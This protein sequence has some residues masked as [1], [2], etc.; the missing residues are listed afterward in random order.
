MKWFL[1]EL[2]L[3]GQFE[4]SESFVSHLKEILSFKEKYISFFKNFYCARGLPEFK[5]SGEITF[6]D[7][8]NSTKDK[9]FIRKVIM[10]LDRNGPF[11]DSVENEPEHDFIY[12]LNGKD[13]IGS[14]LAYAT[15]SLHFRGEVKL[16]SFDG[17]QPNFSYS[18]IQV[19]YCC[20]EEINKIEIENVWNISELEKIAQKYELEKET[21]FLYPDSWSGFLKYISEAFSYV[22]VSTDVENII[23]KQQFNSVVCERGIFLISILDEYVSSRHQDGSYS[24]KTNKILKDY[25]SGGR[26]LFTDESSSNKEQFSNELSFIVNGEKTICSWHGKISYRVFRLHFNYPIKNEDSA[27]NVVYF[28]PK[29]TRK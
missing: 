25:F 7:A 29:L 27:I 23:K 5:V 2:S 3:N 11:I 1:N 13:I 28:G 15:D 19:D 22:K 8:V 6:R 17:S 14:S 16:Y 10:W 20:G 9:N 4:S 12:D 21:S 24:E 26:A 18:P